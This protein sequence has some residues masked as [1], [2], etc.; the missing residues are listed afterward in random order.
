[1]Y[2]Q[3]KAIPV[4]VKRM[5]VL[6]SRM[7]HCLYDLLIRHRSGAVPWAMFVQY[8]TAMAC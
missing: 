6:V 5:A 8:N 7:S 4:Q 2:V 1:M 3:V